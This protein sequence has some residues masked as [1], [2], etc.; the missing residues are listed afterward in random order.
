MKRET[1]KVTRKATKRPARKRERK[2]KEGPFTEGIEFNFQP[3]VPPAPRKV[4]IHYPEV[5]GEEI[6]RAAKVLG[7]EPVDVHAK[8]SALLPKHYPNHLRMLEA[9]VEQEKAGLE[10]K[11]RPYHEAEES[12]HIAGRKF[13]ADEQRRIRTI[14]EIVRKRREIIEPVICS[15]KPPF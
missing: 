4:D 2:A 9:I 7:V 11:C 13:S 15:C 3:F 14:E 8:L 1:K 10:D 12:A 5:W 6:G